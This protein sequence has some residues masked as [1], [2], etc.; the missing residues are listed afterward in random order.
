[1]T[2]IK[3]N[4]HDILKL[5]INQIGITIFALMLYTACGI[6][7]DD[8]LFSQLRTVIS[9][10]SIIFFF[11]L[12]YYVTWE[13]G[14][15]DKIRIEGGRLEP[16]RFRGLLNGLLANVPNLVLGTLTLI[17]SILSFCGVEWSK[18]GFSILYL[19]TSWHASM[20]MGI[21]Q[22]SVYGFSVPDTDVPDYGKY[23]VMSILFL[24]IPL[25]SALVTHIAYT[26]GSKEIKLFGF[27]SSKKK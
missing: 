1:M 17:F 18:A 11:V 10:F 26:L 9:I 20:Y 12:L 21:I 13:E 8:V 23:L 4:F 7:D 6:T 24:L 27:L 14:A 19:I 5:Y 25:V 3:K 15:K 22:T 16:C 2:Y